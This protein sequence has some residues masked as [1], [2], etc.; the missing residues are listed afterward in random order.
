MG[1]AIPERTQKRLNKK[2][3]FLNQLFDDGAKSWKQTM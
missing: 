3:T 1:W 2:K